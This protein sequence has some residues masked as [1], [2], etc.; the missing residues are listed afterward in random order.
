MLW[1]ISNAIAVLT[2]DWMSAYG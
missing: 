1:V 2:T